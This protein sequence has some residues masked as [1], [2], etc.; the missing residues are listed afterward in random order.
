MKNLDLIS[1]ELFNKIRGRF[2][3]VTIGNTEG[4]VTNKPNEARFFDFD[5]K[6]KGKSLGKVSVSLDENS[7]SVMYS[8]NFVE[9]EDKL[10]KE[11]WYNFLK[12]LRYFAKKRLLNFDTRDITKSNLNKTDYKFLAQNNPGESQ[13]TES[14]MY[15]TSKTSYQ[16][17]GKARVSVKHNKPINQELASGRTQHIDTIYIESSEGER[18]KYPFKH[19]NGARAMAMHV[20]EGGK[21]YDDFGKHITGLSEELYKLKKFKSYMGRS[22]VMAEGLSGY[23][24]IVNERVLTVKKTIEG[25]Q[26]LKSYTAMIENF[27]V[28]EI[29]EVPEDVAE[30]WIDQLT[31]RQFNEE[32]KDVFPY[33][34]NLV[35][36]ETKTEELGPDSFI[37]SIEENTES[38]ASDHQDEFNAFEE[39]ADETVDSAL[40]EE[41]RLR[42]ADLADIDKAWPKISQ[43]KMKL[44]DQ[45]MEPEDAQ[46]A[47]AEKLGYDPEMVDHYLNYKFGEGDTDE[48]NAYAH[49]VRKAKMDGKKK[50]DKVMGPDG[51]EITIETVTDYVL[52][53]Y[54][55][56]TGQF[57]K[58]ET[59]VLTA[60]EKDFG[61]S[62]INPAKQFIEAINAKFEEYNGY[63]DPELMDDEEFTL[64]GF[65]SNL[66]EK[67]KAGDEEML[68]AL[69]NTYKDNP[70]IPQKY[71]KLMGRVKDELTNRK[72]AASSQDAGK[73]AEKPK[74][75]D[76]KLDAFGGPGPDIKPTTSMP[77]A[78]AASSQ[79]AGKAADKPQKSF[80][81]DYDYSGSEVTGK[82]GMQNTEY[83]PNYS[84][85][86]E[87][88]NDAEA[89][90]ALYTKGVLSTEERNWLRMAERKYGITDNNLGQVLRKI[91]SD[92]ARR[93]AADVSSFDKS[94]ESV[95]LESIRQ[96]AGI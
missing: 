67:L 75:A 81:P 96:L 77:A 2:P 80:K 27:E 25:I 10:T 59:A 18:F 47:A 23:M 53:M 37:D 88:L 76:D 24:D 74:S 19:L 11:S 86:G 92:V 22:G 6:Q 20:S 73:A 65:L 35:N 63:K 61:E 31:I 49:A 39:W 46:D 71:R 66:D 93:A 95:E 94:Q 36:E 84:G 40:D 32:L 56:N 78:D 91:R 38:S 33:I 72:A 82:Y 28:K 43:L 50:G 60:V 48:G 14:K 34:Y 89:I 42:M 1:E 44:H 16:D 3:S 85:P 5:F 15:G 4:V 26:K 70:M 30:N 8:N 79:D 21:V 57:P 9:N 58:G 64:E 68:L 17:V 90:E 41:P 87:Y 55:R 13:M 83:D 7:V 12:E 62:F 51:K 54:D 29:K 52:S 69:Y 45:G